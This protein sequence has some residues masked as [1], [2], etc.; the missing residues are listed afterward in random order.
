M[1]TSTRHQ[2]QEVAGTSSSGWKVKGE[3]NAAER[4]GFKPST[5]RDRIK[6]LGIVRSGA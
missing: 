3:G 6:K 4:L 5:L 1:G 2:Q